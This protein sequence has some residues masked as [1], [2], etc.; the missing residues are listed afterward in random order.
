MNNSLFLIWKNCNVHLN[1]SVDSLHL[2]I[3]PTSKIVKMS[4]YYDYLYL[5]TEK[6]LILS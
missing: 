5:L 2:K 6:V 4:G 3:A 1:I